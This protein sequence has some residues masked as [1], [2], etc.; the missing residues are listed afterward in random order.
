M[1]DA[2]HVYFNPEGKSRAQLDREDRR[3]LRA[4]ERWAWWTIERRCMIGGLALFV[5]AFAVMF[6]V[7][8]AQRAGI[9]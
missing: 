2:Y 5:L 3:R 8:W 1:S 6:F 7:E 9:L 4:Q